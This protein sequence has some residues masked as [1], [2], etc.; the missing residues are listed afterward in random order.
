MEN[1]IEMFWSDWGKTSRANV[2]TNG[3]HSW[4]LHHDNALAHALLVMR[5]FS[6]STNMIVI[7]H[8]SYSLD[9]SPCGFFLFPKMKL[10]LKE[11][12]FDSNEGIQTESQDVMKVLMR[13]DFQQC[14]RSWKCHWDHCIN[15][16]WDNFKVGGG[17]QKFG[18]WLSCGRRISGTFV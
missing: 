11:Q 12:C 7:L 17:K 5:Q 16:E 1:S 15:S 3:K 6:A 8:L 4:A 14:F 2:Q 10:K 13:N 9:L 18:R